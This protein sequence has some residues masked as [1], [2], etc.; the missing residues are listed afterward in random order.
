A[1]TLFR[2]QRRSAAEDLLTARRLG[3][4]GHAVR[5]LDDEIANV[6]ERRDAGTAGSATGERPVVR[7]DQVFVRTIELADERRGDLVLTGLQ[8][9]RLG[10]HGH[11][12]A[13]AGPAGRTGLVLDQRD[14]LAVDRHVDVLEARVRSRHEI[15]LEDV[16][17]VG[18]K[19][20][21]DDQ[22]AA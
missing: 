9:N 18:R 4:A 20:M 6:W 3:D 13:T 8:E 21:I 16:L 5:S 10:A 19:H 1:R 12:A 14:A 17:G 22:A 2:G 11:G 7:P 15:D